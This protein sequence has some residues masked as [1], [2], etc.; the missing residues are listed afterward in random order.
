MQWLETLVGSKLHA[1]CVAILSAVATTAPRLLAAAATG[2]ATAW[3]ALHTCLKAAAR[4]HLD[5]A[6][7]APLTYAVRSKWAQMVRVAEI[8]SQ[9][10]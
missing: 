4:E 6:G 3:Q 7:V 5:A 8:E 10:E 9:S 2:L 1:D